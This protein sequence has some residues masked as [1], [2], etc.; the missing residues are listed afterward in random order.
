MTCSLRTRL[1]IGAV[2]TIVLLLTVFSLILYVVI[3]RALV[4]QFDTSLLSTA[5]MLA[6]SVEQDGSE[7]EL[8]FEARQLPEFND[9]QRPTYYQI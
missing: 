1:V 8:E 7:I 4:N 2:G 9:P 6:A 3:R 5:R